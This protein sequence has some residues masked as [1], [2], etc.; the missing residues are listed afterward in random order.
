MILS[1]L[2]KLRRLETEEKFLNL[3]ASLAVISLFFPWLSG[4]WIADQIRTDTALSFGSYVSFIGLAILVL[5]GFVLLATAVP[6]WNGKQL[7]RS[8]RKHTIRFS[9]SAVS[10]ILT[11]AALSVLLKVTF[12]FPSMQI[13]FGVYAALIGSSLATLYAYL[14]TQEQ[15][16]RHVQ[17]LFHQETADRLEDQ[18]QLSLSGIPV[19]AEYLSPETSTPAAPAPESHR[20]VVR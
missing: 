7:L 8:E 16:R 4:R 20:T 13:R 11:L 18:D 2:Q 15:R 6:L 9:C 3:G 10:A 14:L 12:D 17:T 5:Q 19:D 1:F